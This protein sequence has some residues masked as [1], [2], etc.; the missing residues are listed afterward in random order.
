MSL[1]HS[2]GGVRRFQHVLHGHDVDSVHLY[3]FRCCVIIVHVHVDRRCTRRWGDHGV[4]RIDSNA[5]A[6]LCI[7]VIVFANG[8]VCFAIHHI[9]PVGIGAGK[10]IADAKGRKMCTVFQG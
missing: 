10:G 9:E 3:A 2:E 4:C 7:D 5:I 1:A 6:V 8:G